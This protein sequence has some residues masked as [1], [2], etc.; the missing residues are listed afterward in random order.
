VL[1]AVRLALAGQR[2]PDEATFN[3]LRAAGLMRG[4]RTT[5]ARFRCDIY[6]T[7]LSRHLLHESK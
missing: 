7:Y 4:S 6:K 1:D 2:V 5:D 3:R